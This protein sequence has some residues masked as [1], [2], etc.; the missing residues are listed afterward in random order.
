MSPREMGL[1]L[2]WRRGVIK[3]Q[4]SIASQGA[5]G[6]IEILVA[7]NV[8]K[9]AGA[10]APAPEQAKRRANASEMKLPPLRLPK[11]IDPDDPRIPKGRYA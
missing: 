9:R 5:S 6:M 1:A 10:A 11:G 8:L 7:L 3:G 2:E 4:Q